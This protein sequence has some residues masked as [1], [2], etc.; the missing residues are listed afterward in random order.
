MEKTKKQKD[1]EERLRLEFIVPQR[2][3]KE[4]PKLIKINSLDYVM[5]FGKYVGKT[6]QY[7]MET[8]A[9]YINWLHNEHIKGIFVSDH[10]LAINNEFKI[11]Q[12]LSWEKSNREKFVSR[13]NTKNA[14][15]DSYEEDDLP[16]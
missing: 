1:E 11:S 4:L 14:K 16:F 7:I 13:Q 5:T 2:M 3:A 10:I 6:I 15:F 12:Q 9:S 8:E